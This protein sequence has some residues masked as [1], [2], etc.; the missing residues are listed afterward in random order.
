MIFHD[1]GHHD[2]PIICIFSTRKGAIKKLRSIMTRKEYSD[3]IDEDILEMLN[4]AENEKG[5]I[6]VTNDVEITMKIV[7]KKF[8]SDITEEFSSERNWA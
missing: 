1:Y 7:N 8:G 3:Q 4:E 6:D 2:M 5:D